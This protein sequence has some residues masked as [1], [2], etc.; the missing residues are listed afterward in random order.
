[1]RFSRC[2]RICTST[3]LAPR[4]SAGAA[5]WTERAMTPSPLFDRKT[6]AKPSIGRPPRRTGKGTAEVAGASLAPSARL[7]QRRLHDGNAVGAQAAAP[8]AYPGADD[9]PED[10]GLPGR[11][12]G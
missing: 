6:M 4:C 7:V 2:C 5:S 8:V 3:P 1:M 11:P 10:Q 12:F 9:G